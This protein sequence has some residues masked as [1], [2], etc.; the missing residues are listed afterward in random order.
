M[1]RVHLPVY[2]SRYGY[3][4]SST[5]PHKDMTMVVSYTL[6]VKWSIVWR[7]YSFTSSFQSLR[8]ISCSWLWGRRHSTNVTVRYSQRLQHGRRLPFHNA[9]IS[10]I[11]RHHGS[12]W[13]CWL[14]RLSGAQ[15]LS[16]KWHEPRSERYQR[17]VGNIEN[18]W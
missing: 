18:A 6:L 2:A 15:S 14:S 13:W 4:P 11:S 9:S 8:M 5:Q 7:I 1:M 17:M 3:L 16:E 12:A 10:S